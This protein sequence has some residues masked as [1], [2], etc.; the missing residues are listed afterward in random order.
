MEEDGGG[1]EGNVHSRCPSGREGEGKGEEERRE[2]VSGGGGGSEGVSQG[3]GEEV[4]GKK[5][6]VSPRLNGALVD[7]SSPSEG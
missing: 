6:A 2:E 3:A 4:K 5:E 1:V 7:P